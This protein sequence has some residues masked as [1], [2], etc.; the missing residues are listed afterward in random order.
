[1]GSGATPK[2]GEA[3]YK[4]TGTPLIR[5]MN[6]VFFGFKWDGLAYLDDAQ[7]E[8]LKGV[9][10]HGHDVLLNI[11]GASIGRVTIAPNELSGARVNQHVCIIRPVREL[12]ARFLNAYLSCPTMQGAITDENY[13]V[14]RQA[15]T[16]QQILDFEIPIAPLPEQK[17]IADKLDAL[18]ARVDACRE[19]LDRVPGILKRFRQSVLAAAASGE[20]TREW[21]EERGIELE[22]RH[23]VVADV[24]AQIFDGPFGS[25]L[26]SKDYADEGV[27]VVRLENIAPLRFIEEKRTFIPREKYEGLTKHTLFAGDI[28]FSSFVDEEVRV[29]LLPEQLDGKA[30]N[31]A[32][33]FCVRT[34]INLCRP[35]FLALRLACR[36]TFEALD[37]AVHGATRPRINLGQ[38]KEISFD[39]PSLYEQDEIIRRSGAL[40]DLAD[41]L[42]LRL[43]AVRRHV[44]RLLPSALGKAFR[45]ELVPQDPNDEP[46]SNFLVRLRSRLGSAGS[47]DKPMRGGKRGSRKKAKA[48][49]NMLSRK[50]VT[51][52]H[53]T[54]KLRDSGS[55]TAQALWTASQLEIDDFYEQLKDEEARGLLREN[56]GDSSTDART[57]EASA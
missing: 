51:P 7:A 1:V 53:L 12:D 23:T 17:R 24:A 2:G 28:L 20:L 10:V 16:K 21:R 48:E 32:D 43:A 30:I 11:T 33:C 50:D 4:S 6:V 5:S 14:T 44:D 38:L 25:H 8:A 36:S 46:A 19:R 57:L 39:L 49:M 26:K 9:E 35:S 31:K 3:A 45:G 54:I 56:R 15:L 13:G 18:L 27:R 42:E 47:T 40:L 22:W 55:L 34:N 37:D 29:C 52:T 41:A